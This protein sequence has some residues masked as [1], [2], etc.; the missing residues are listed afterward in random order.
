MGEVNRKFWI[1]VV[2]IA[3]TL[4]VLYVWAGLARLGVSP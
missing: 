2:T 4:A 1:V 3:V